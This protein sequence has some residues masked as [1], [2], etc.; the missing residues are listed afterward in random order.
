MPRTGRRRATDGSN[1]TITYA[2]DGNNQRV[3]S[4]LQGTPAITTVFVYDAAGQLISNYSSGN[5]VTPQCQT[6]YMSYDHLGSTRLITDELAELVSRHDF[7]PFGEEVP[8]NTAGRSLI[9]G[10]CGPEGPAVAGFFSGSGK[11]A[12]RGSAFRMEAIRSIDNPSCG[13]RIN[14]CFPL[15]EL[16]TRG[17]VSRQAFSPASISASCDAQDARFRSSSSESRR[18]LRYFPAETRVHRPSRL[19]E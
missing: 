7:L 4:V 16:G 11:F 13:A 8:A 17:D 14:L 1:N 15:F 2:Y 5:E 6:C 19:K 10:S 9:N 18:R 12:D 3:A